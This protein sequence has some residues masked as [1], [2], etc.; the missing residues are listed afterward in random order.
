M[1]LL[2]TRQLGT[3]TS[4]RVYLLFQRSLGFV[5]NSAGQKPNPADILV[6]TA[7][8]LKKLDVGI[9]RRSHSDSPESKTR[10]PSSYFGFVGGIG[11][12]PWA[13]L[14]KWEVVLRSRSTCEWLV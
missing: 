1:F 2:T 4:P 6:P 14:G 10:K 7:A 5:G 9:E 13:K 11:D 3:Y 12:P 8:M